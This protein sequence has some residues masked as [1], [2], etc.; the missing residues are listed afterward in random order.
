MHQLGYELPERTG[1][2]G[3]WAEAAV[4]KE[5]V[6][7]TAGAL[8]CERQLVAHCEGATSVRARDAISSFRRACCDVV[9]A[10]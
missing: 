3:L 7:A 10:A 9:V 8:E 5:S 6:D 2:G 4:E 1:F